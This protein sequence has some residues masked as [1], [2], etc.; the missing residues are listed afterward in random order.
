MSH[1]MPNPITSLFGNR[2]FNELFAL[3]LGPQYPWVYFIERLESTLPNGSELWVFF[4]L[5]RPAHL[6]GVNSIKTQLSSTE[7]TQSACLI[8]CLTFR[9][10]RGIKWEINFALRSSISRSTCWSTSQKMLTCECDAIGV[11]FVLRWHFHYHC[12]SVTFPSTRT[13]ASSVRYSR[14]MRQYIELSATMWNGYA[15]NRKRTKPY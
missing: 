9:S 6:G 8:S 4:W 14:R 11:L 13:V 7:S 3:P 1:R 15:R 12:Y 2:K 10:A 5:D